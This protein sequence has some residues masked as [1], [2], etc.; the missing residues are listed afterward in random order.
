MSRPQRTAKRPKWQEEEEKEKV[1]MPAGSKSESPS[2]RGRRDAASNKD[3]EE[4]GAKTEAAAAE[5]DRADDENDGGKTESAAEEGDEEEDGG[6]EEQTQE[7]GAGQNANLHPA[8]VAPSSATSAQAGRTTAAA[9]QVIRDVPGKAS[10]SGTA[11]P[12]SPALTA[13]AAVAAAVQAAAAMAEAQK[14]KGGS[15]Q[16]DE[17]R[18][19]SAVVPGAQAG[20]CDSPQASQALAAAAAAVAAAAAAGVNPA[21]VSQAMMQAQPGDSSGGGLMPVGWAAQG[22]AV[23]NAMAGLGAHQLALHKWAHMHGAPIPVSVPEP[24]SQGAAGAQHSATQ[25]GWSPMHYA[26]LATPPIP[27]AGKRAG[28]PTSPSHAHAV[29]SGKHQDGS[30]AQLLHT[31]TSVTGT[32]LPL[33][34]HAQMHAPRPGAMAS[35]DETRQKIPGSPQRQKFVMWTPVDDALLKSS[36]EGGMSLTDI[37]AHIPFTSEFSVRDIEV[38]WRAMLYDPVVSM[39]VSVE[40]AALQGGKKINLPQ[41]RKSSGALDLPREPSDVTR[42]SAARSYHPATAGFLLHQGVTADKVSDRVTAVEE[43]TSPPSN[44]RSSLAGLAAVDG[45][46]SHYLIFKSLVVLGR[47]PKLGGSQPVVGEVE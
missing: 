18:D 26:S 12:S 40:I 2:S 29:A 16:K 17:D 38:R 31:P 47:K 21:V 4:R 8:S 5:S 41:K 30:N 35:S 1:G 39:E 43:R 3:G 14:A 13:I 44:V 34:S 25:S 22:I 46:N 15:P 7:E 36:V 42:S 33:E 11:A 9:Q 45:A 32:V 19:S 23:A 10:S 20:H 24:N 27:A 6:E 37:A 28:G